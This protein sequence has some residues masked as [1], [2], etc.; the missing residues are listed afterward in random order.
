MNK[1][2]IDKTLEL[3]IN[4]IKENKGGSFSCII[5]QNNTIIETGVN[6]ITSLNVL[7]VHA[8][9]CAIHEACKNINNFLLKNCVMYK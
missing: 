4:N 8:E 3:T 6:K 5:I 2:F 7:T 1:K 9:I